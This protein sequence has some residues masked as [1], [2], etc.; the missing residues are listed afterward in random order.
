MTI[1]DLGIV[2][3]RILGVLLL[4]NGLAGLAAM[5]GFYMGDMDPMVR[6]SLTSQLASVA[7]T[8][9]VGLVLVLGGRWI[10]EHLFQEGPSVDAATFGRADLLGILFAALGA[11]VIT[12]AIPNLVQLVLNF[13]VFRGLDYEY[14]REQFWQENWIAVV[15]ESVRFG[16]GVFLVAGGRGLAA[17]WARLRPLSQTVETED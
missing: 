1:R 9:I 11:Y 12:D 4:A 16:L 10:G 6:L 2:A 8:F 15:A 17:A 3:L 14:N 7:I 13:W 5:S